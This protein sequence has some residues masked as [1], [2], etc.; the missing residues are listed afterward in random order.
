MIPTQAQADLV[1]RV[2]ELLVGEPSTREV[3]MFGGRAFMVAESMVVSAHRSGDLL[4]RV[5]AERHDEL[6]ARPGAEQAEMGT[7]RTMGPGWVTV[8]AATL[9]SVAD[10][11]AWLDIALDHNRAVTGRDGGTGA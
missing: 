7:G 5:P 8:S 3:S 9:E 2:R 1:Q 10:L 6:L 11:S 4:V